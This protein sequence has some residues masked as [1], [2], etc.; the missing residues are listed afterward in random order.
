[1]VLKLS[2]PGYVGYSRL[3][4]IF[5]L[6][7]GFTKL[8]IQTKGSSAK[9]QVVTT[10][11]YLHSWSKIQDEIKARRICMVEWCGGS[12]TKKEILSRLH[13]REEAA[14]KRE[15]TMAY[16][17][18]HQWRA[19]SSQGLGNYELGKAS[20]SWSW[21]DRWIAA[22]PVRQVSETKI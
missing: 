22:L 11:T 8:K 5:T 6:L 18:S 12:E 7:T 4:K 3:L 15:R 16:A 2:S 10:I 19:S 13:Q 14:V 20:W 17:L 9:K 21:N 1:M